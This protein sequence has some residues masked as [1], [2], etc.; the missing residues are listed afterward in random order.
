MAV[1][2][3]YKGISMYIQQL[4]PGYFKIICNSSIGLNISSKYKEN[5]LS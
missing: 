1:I 4:W 2:H 3:I 5:W